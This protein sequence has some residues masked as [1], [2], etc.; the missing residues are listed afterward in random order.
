M[1]FKVII[2]TV[3]FFVQLIPLKAWMGC[4]NFFD[5][6]HFSLYDLELQLIYAI[7]H[8][9]GLPVLLA[10]TF[11][12]KLLQFFIDVYKRYTH[13]LDPQLLITL[14]T[15]VG[16]FGVV[17][18]IWYFLN[19]QNR[20]KKLGFLILVSFGIPLLEVLINF[21]LP[22]IYKILVV[23]IPFNLLSLFG[24]YMFLRPKNIKTVL[25][26]YFILIVLSVC[27]IILIPDQVLKY[28]EV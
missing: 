16:A 23:A 8:D 13:F 1:R 15:F 9:Q 4:K 2:I 7:N 12:N 11:H 6:Y 19:S 3:L 18:S 24:H 22:F 14:L 10:R 21:K 25:L 5:Y 20:N 28:C 27:W 17:I 26:I